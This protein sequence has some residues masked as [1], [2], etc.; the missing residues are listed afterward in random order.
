[1]LEQKLV[2]SIDLYS[3]RTATTREYDSTR[4]HNVSYGRTMQLYASVALV[5]AHNVLVRSQCCTR[6]LHDLLHSLAAISS[7]RLVTAL[8]AMA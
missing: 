8:S 3:Y 4:A 1:M 6:T 2:W 5:R 7:C